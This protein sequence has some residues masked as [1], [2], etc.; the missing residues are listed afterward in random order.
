MCLN[1]NINWKLQ[2]HK[3]KTKEI[4]GEKRRFAVSEFVKTCDELIIGIGFYELMDG[5]ASIFE[6]EFVKTCDELIA[7]AFIELFFPSYK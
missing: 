4:F 1:F 2:A 5:V 6:K 7:L 3:N